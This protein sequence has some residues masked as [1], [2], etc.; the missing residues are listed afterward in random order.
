M[1]ASDER[2]RIEVELV[3]GADADSPFARP[4]STG[5]TDAS[6]SG[7]S[8]GS[9]DRR[10]VAVVVAVAVAAL[11]LGWYLGRSGTDPAPEV[12]DAAPVATVARIAVES[13]APATAATP[14]VPNATAPDDTAPDE[15]TD[16]GAAD[17]DAGD[18]TGQVVT[19]VVV[20]AAVAGQPV[21]VIA[22]GNG[23]QLWRLDLSTG[24][25]VTQDVR[26]QPFGRVHLVVGE[27]WIVFPPADPELPTIVVDDAGLVGEAS[28][29]AAWQI[30]GT[31]DG[32]GLWV[33]SPELSD[34]GV[35][36][37]ERIPISSGERT[38]LTLPGPPSRLDPL[39]GFVVDSPGGSYSVTGDGVARITA[40]ELIAI[41]RDVAVAEECDEVLACAVV[42]IDRES[43]ARRPLAVE[44]P[45]DP[46]FLRSIG[47]IGTESVAPGGDLAMV[48]VVNP[49]D[50]SS[51]QPTIGVLDL[52]TGEVSEIG[53]AQDIDQAAWSPDG[54]LLFY[55]RGGKPVAYD[56]A[57]G[58]VHTLA[59]EL[60]AVE[61]FGTRPVS[62]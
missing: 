58:E 48:Q 31:T 38:E 23:R 1:G 51:G 32:G 60:L 25:L 36:T 19:D 55:I 45:L 54:T 53:P 47:I 5:T 42:A 4:A 7:E 13:I 44:R 46:R 40:G 16:D 9:Q 59:A 33:M 34:G 3:S 41:G 56:H 27:D 57:T 50:R 24:R 21:E 61:S 12:S 43:G 18:A 15:V 28:L 17:E 14:T 20:P 10:V 37:I 35:G 52:D 2:Q 22:F 6:A 49:A 39:G 30:V 8:G 11:A 62:P 29:G 26:R